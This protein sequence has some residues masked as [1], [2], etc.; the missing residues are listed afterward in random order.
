MQLQLAAQQQQ[1]QQQSAAGVQELYANGY[2]DSAA[3]LGA[4]GVNG[5][6]QMSNSRDRQS[7][8]DYR[9]DSNRTKIQRLLCAATF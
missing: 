4:G 6:K 2:V 7:T 9:C 8:T 5:Q 3:V 1:Q